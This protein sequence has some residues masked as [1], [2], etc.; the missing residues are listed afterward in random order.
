M[1]IWHG[2][3]EDYYSGFD[4][5]YNIND[6]FSLTVIDTSKIVL[7]DFF[8]LNFYDTL[9]YFASSSVPFYPLSFEYYGIGVPRIEILYYY[10]NDSTTISYSNTES[11]Y[12]NL[13]NLHS[14]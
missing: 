10:L 8:S 11:G 4:T 7:H 14:P 5:S 12:G 9:Y 13:I 3:E 6:T 2:T 1:R